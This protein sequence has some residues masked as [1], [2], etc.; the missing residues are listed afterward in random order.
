MANIILVKT[1]GCVSQPH[2]VDGEKNRDGEEIQL[3]IEECS[4]GIPPIG[5]DSISMLMNQDPGIQQFH[6]KM[7]RF[8]P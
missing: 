1:T 3:D 5:M 2:H 7:C 4:L 6:E 8:F